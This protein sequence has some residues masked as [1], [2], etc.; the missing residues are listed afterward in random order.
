ML[1]FYREKKQIQK[2]E[3]IKAV[4]YN[5]T[6]ISHSNEKTRK[7]S[8][9]NVVCSDVLNNFFFFLII[10]NYQQIVTSTSE[11]RNS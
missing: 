1:K 5:S 6:S 3:R 7:E 2:K 8:K 11:E 4:T 9:E 10:I